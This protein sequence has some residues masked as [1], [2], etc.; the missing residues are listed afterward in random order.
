MCHSTTYVIIC[1]LTSNDLLRRIEKK[2]HS[3]IEV[4]FWVWGLLLTSNKHF[5]VSHGSLESQHL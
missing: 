4:C 1:P 3:M 2:T 5:C